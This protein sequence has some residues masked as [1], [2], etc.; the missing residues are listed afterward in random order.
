MKVYGEVGVYLHPFLTSTLDACGQLQLFGERADGIH[1]IGG[2]VD[3]G[4]G[5]LDN[6]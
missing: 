2:L 5:A 3:P 1:S 6:Y 4:A